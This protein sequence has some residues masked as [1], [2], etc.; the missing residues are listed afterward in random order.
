MKY[1]LYQHV[2]LDTNLIF[3]IGKGTKC[4]KGNIYKRAFTKNSRN[5]YW[6]NIV[7]SIP[8]KV[9]IIEEFEYE[10]DCLKKETELIIKYGYSWN[11]T[12][13]LCNVVKDNEEIKF[14]ARKQ[15]NISNSKKVYQYDLEGNYIKS[16]SSISKAK[17]E[18]PSDIY[19]AITLRSKT[20][21]GF[22][23]RT[24]KVSNIS[25]YDVLLNR[26]SKSK[27]IYQYSLDNLLIQEW[28]GTKD[29]SEKLKI[30]R[31]SI[32]NCLSGSAISAG[33]YK[34]SYSEELSIQNLPKKY[35]VYKDTILIYSHNSLK[36]C[37]EYV[38]INPNFASVYMRRNKVYN[39]YLFK[40][41]DKKT[42]RHP[43][44]HAQATVQHWKKRLRHRN[45]HQ[46]NLTT[47][48]HGSAS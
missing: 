17:K 18:F 39:G 15:S 47:P 34:W 23:W 25:P 40:Y 11:N 45:R 32:R 20:A 3:Y 2:R 14:L 12:G 48:Q 19:N 9:E 26:I 29:P 24:Y 13:I 35:S 44:P 30:N 31:G 42:P 46:N 36:R 4:K 16:F 10:E 27:K 6:K 28:Y 38:N 22:Q 21:G 7:N 8:Y 37:A 33:G 5:N 43:C 1:Y 41:H